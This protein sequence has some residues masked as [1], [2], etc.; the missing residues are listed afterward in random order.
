[1][2]TGVEGTNGATRDAGMGIDSLGGAVDGAR[3]K[4]NM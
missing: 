4:V 3:G 2:N 1:M